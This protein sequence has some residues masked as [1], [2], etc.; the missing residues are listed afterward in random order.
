MFTPALI[1]PV[2]W[3]LHLHPPLCLGVKSLTLSFAVAL[4][5]TKNNPTRWQWGD[6]HCNCPLPPS[7]AHAQPRYPRIQNL[8]VVSDPP[9]STLPPPS[10]HHL[11]CHPSVSILL[12]VVAFAVV[13]R[14]RQRCPRTNAQCITSWLSFCFCLFA[15]TLGEQALCPPL[16]QPTKP[17]QCHGLQAHSIKPQGQSP[18]TPPASI[19]RNAICQAMAVVEGT[20]P[21]STPTPRLTP[22]TLDGITLPPPPFNATAERRHM[23]LV[24]HPVRSHKEFPAHAC[25][26]SI[27]SHPSL[28]YCKNED[29]FW[30]SFLNFHDASSE[31]K[32][33]VL[34][35]R[36]RW[37]QETK[38][39]KMAPKR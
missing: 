24:I 1:T 6:S 17:Q 14:H 16:M 36:M 13:H 5:P 9:L 21:P 3:L 27:S 33:L 15:Y 10:F 38:G 18:S 20:P 34:C 2:I 28:F 22:I 37:V 12:V 30:C 35:L 39:E 31:L 19:S 32:L 7:N 11:V 26:H 29:K 23:R 25:C 8:I 4:T